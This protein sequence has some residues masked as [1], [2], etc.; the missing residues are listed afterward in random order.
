MRE[1]LQAR[2]LQSLQRVG[3]MQTLALHGGTGLRLL[4]DIPAILKIWILPWNCS[5]KNTIF[6]PICTRQ[7]DFAAEAYTIDIKKTRN[8]LAIKRLSGFA[9]CFMNWGCPGTN[10]K[11]WRLKLRVDPNPPSHAGLMT[12]PLEKH[13]LLHLQRRGAGT[14]YRP[15]RDR[16]NRTGSVIGRRLH[17]P[18]RA[19]RCPERE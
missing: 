16:S 9:G 2:I 15:D 1:F 6:A 10:P 18:G 5:P 4:Y 13:I 3:A 8:G 17:A 19:R 14:V 12:T 7:S 11:G